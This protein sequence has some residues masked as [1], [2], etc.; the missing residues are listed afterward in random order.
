MTVD[1]GCPLTGIVVITVDQ[2]FQAVQ[3]ILCVNGLR[4]FKHAATKLQNAVKSHRDMISNVLATAQ[5]QYDTCEKRQN[6]E[7][8]V[9]EQVLKFRTQAA[10]QFLTAAKQSYQTQMVQLISFGMQRLKR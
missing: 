7:N 4:I 6:K 2:G 8:I 10:K 5:N 9:C 1:R 3:F